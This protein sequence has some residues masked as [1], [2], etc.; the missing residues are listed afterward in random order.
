M[1]N[2]ADANV[3]SVLEAAAGGGGVLVLDLR[4][5]RRILDGVCDV[6]RECGEDFVV[7]HA[8]NLVRVSDILAVNRPYHDLRD[9]DGD[10]A[11]WCSLLNLAAP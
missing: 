6:R 10:G 8:N 1:M 11:V 7:L 9:E 3:L 4:D 5:G 2:G